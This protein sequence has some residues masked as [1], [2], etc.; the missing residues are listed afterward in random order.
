MPAQVRHEE[1]NSI[2]KEKDCD[3]N[4][5]R[6]AVLVANYFVMRTKEQLLALVRLVCEV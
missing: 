6:V 3:A 5:V 4:A 2:C 1:M